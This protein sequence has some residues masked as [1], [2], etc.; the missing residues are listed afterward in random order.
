MLCL[1]WFR[2]VALG[3]YGEV[4]GGSR[5][6]YL[7]NRIRMF[8]P[9]WTLPQ[10]HLHNQD[11]WCTCISTLT[12]SE[13]YREMTMLL[14]SSNE[15]NIRLLVFRCIAGF[16]HFYTYLVSIHYQVKSVFGDTYLSGA[17]MQSIESIVVFVISAC[18]LPGWRCGVP[19]HATKL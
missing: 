7:G 13:L 5:I 2:N 12:P 6:A 18:G 16:S 10:S 3:S 15:P 1:N 8:Q 11:G 17:D 19:R 9:I 4:N 14:W